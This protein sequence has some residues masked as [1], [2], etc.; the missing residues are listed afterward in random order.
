MFPD[1][2]KMSELISALM[3][4]LNVQGVNVITY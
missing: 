1:A 3:Y 4:I 2:S